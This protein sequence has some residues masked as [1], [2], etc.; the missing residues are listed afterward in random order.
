MGNPNMNYDKDHT[1]LFVSAG[2]LCVLVI[3][4]IIALI[5]KGQKNTLS[6]EPA[7]AVETVAAVE[8]SSPADEQKLEKSTLSEVQKFTKAI[9]MEA[10]TNSIAQYSDLGIVTCDS[11]INFRSAPD[12]NDLT[13]I[14]GMLANGSAVDIIEASPENTSGWMHV[15]SGGMDGYVASAFVVTGDDFRDRNL[16]TS[17]NVTLRDTGD[18]DCR[19]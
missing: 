1:M 4:I 17:I 5:V 16:V 13:N 14:M 12:Q 7:S 15:R 2:I 18:I 6:E 9:Q 8:N 19:I 3:A 10:I 11:Y